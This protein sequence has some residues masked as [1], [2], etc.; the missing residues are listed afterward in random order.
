MPEFTYFNILLISLMFSCTSMMQPRINNG[1]GHSDCVF[2]VRPVHPNMWPSAR[3]L[4]GP[5]HRP[6][7]FVTHKLRVI[8]KVVVL[9]HRTNVERYLVG[10]WFGNVKFYSQVVAAIV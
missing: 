4:L 5:R 10:G 2:V 6:Q 3:S 8:L 9:N 1:Q 7:F